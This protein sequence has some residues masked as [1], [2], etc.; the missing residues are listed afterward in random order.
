MHYIQILTSHSSS[1][2]QYFNEVSPGFEKDVLDGVAATIATLDREVK[3]LRKDFA[4]AAFPDVLD[5]PVSR[6]EVEV[7]QNLHHNVHRHLATGARERILQTIVFDRIDDRFDNVATAHWATLHWATQR[8]S[9]TDVQW[10][11]L[12]AWME[13]QNPHSQMYWITGRPGS[14]KSTLMRHLVRSD[15]C[16]QALNRWASPRPLLLLSCFFWNPGTT[17]QKSKEGL[18]RTLVHQMASSEYVTDSRLALRH[19][20]VWDDWKYLSS[21]DRLNPSFGAIANLFEELLDIVLE[22]CNVALFIDGLDEFGSTREDREELLTHITDLTRRP[23]LK[24]CF[25]SRPWN[26]FSD[27]LKYSPHLR[28]EDLT[29]DDMSQY[30]LE[31]F[32]SSQAFKE[33]SA[34]A[35][36]EVL[37]LQNLLVSKSNGVFLWLYLVVSKVKVAAQDGANMGKLQALIDNVPPDLDDF[38]RHMLE[39]IPEEDRVQSARIFQLLINGS[40]ESLPDLMTLSF[41]DEDEL[42]FSLL[43]RL[44][45]EDVEVIQT[46]VMAFRRRL[47]SQCLDLLVTNQHTGASGGLFWDHVYVQYLHRSVR[48]FLRY[49]SSQR[50]LMGYAGESLHVTRYKLNAAVIQLHFLNLSRGTPGT[51]AGDAVLADRMY[52][53]TCSMYA[54]RSLDPATCATGRQLYESAVADLTANLRGVHLGTIIAQ[55][56]ETWNTSFLATAT[57]QSWPFDSNPSAII[58]EFQHLFIRPDAYLFLFMSI[59][60]SLRCLALYYLDSIEGE[61]SID[62]YLRC[63]LRAKYWDGDIYNKV[64]ARGRSFQY[65]STAMNILALIHR[66]IE[67]NEP[68][69]DN[70]MLHGIA[71]T[72]QSLLVKTKGASL[73]RDHNAVVL[74]M[75]KT[76]LKDFATRDYEDLCATLHEVRKQWRQPGQPV[77]SPS[78]PQ[79]FSRVL[80]KVLRF[81]V[82]KPSRT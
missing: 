75:R 17:M 76:F 26:I 62:T 11:N 19:S 72:V 63:G 49:E 15:V 70:N 21:K 79:G 2:R 8:D 51:P 7:E 48:D 78:R 24:G 30:V 20:S 47:S 50:L 16:W 23:R 57:D 65:V 14:G 56:A 41:T 53:F 27:V 25:A 3:S 13:D 55:E 42:D 29:R 9:Q 34:I 39:R 44:R 28:L 43:K 73:L 54:L 33:L 80:P 82:G 31:E 52:Y 68:N 60:W 6:R 71:V 66:F 74:S 32:A 58:G 69:C 18:L 35:S 64:I 77:P 67:A 38:F 59:L 12:A 36:K 4:N 61:L 37:R 1:E 40:H 5:V 22:E 10:S 46:R 81:S 45:E